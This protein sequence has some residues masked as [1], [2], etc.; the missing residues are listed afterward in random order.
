MKGDQRGVR[1]ELLTAAFGRWLL[2]DTG[3]RSAICSK[4]TSYTL[5]ALVM[6]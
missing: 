4:G 2:W 3:Q 1:A 5:S 6:T